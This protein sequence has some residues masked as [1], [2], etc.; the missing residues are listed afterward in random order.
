[1]RNGGMVMTVFDAL[2]P[3]QAKGSISLLARSHDEIIGGLEME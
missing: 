3:E 1:M 2:V